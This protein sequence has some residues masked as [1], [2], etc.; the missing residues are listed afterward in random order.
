MGEQV[1]PDRLY[2]VKAELDASGIYLEHRGDR[3]CA[4]VLRP[5]AATKAPVITRR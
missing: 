4:D 5:E 1:D 2:E 3:F